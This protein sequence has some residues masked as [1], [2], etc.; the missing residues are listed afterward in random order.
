MICPEGLIAPLEG[1]VGEEGAGM[2]VVVVSIGYRLGV[3]VSSVMVYKNRA[4]SCLANSR[5][6]MQPFTDRRLPQFLYFPH[7][8]VH[9]LSNRGSSLPRKSSQK[10]PQ[11]VWLVTL[12]ST[13]NDSL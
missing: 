3:F 4:G 11:T 2:E 12:V 13:I 1:K 10:I 7:L 8:R 6:E 5:C 9:L